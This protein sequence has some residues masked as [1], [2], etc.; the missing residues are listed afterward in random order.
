MQIKEDNK[1]LLNQRVALLRE[2]K[3][4]TVNEFIAQFVSSKKFLDAF[5]MKPKEVL[6]TKQMLE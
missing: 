2:R 4:S 6:E 3:N 1:Y 5:L